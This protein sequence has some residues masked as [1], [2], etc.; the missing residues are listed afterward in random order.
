MLVLLLDNL[1][2]LFIAVLDVCQ[3]GDFEGTLTSIGMTCAQVASQPWLCYQNA[4]ADSC[5]ETCGN[6][7]IASQA[8]NL[9]RQNNQ[10]PGRLN[11]GAFVL[12]LN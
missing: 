10:P 12:I 2:C 7:Y 6:V 11:L 4:V 9:T 3:Y 5:C 8:G 1:H